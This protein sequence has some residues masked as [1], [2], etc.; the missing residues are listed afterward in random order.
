LLRDRDL[1]ASR[2]G[3]GTWVTWAGHES[4]SRAAGFRVTSTL[5]DDFKS[6]SG[7]DDLIDLTDA[8]VA[9]L[10]L[11]GNVA[12]SLSAETFSS[13]ITDYPY[14]HELL[15][16]PPL[17]EAV[18]AEYCK[19]G[20]STRPDQILIT[21]GS[22]QALKL[23]AESYL[24]E[25]SSVVVEGPTY[26]GALAVFRSALA[27][28]HSVRTD[29]AGVLP[30]HLEHV[31]R[32]VQPRL[33]YLVPTVHNPTGTCLPPAR[34]AAVAT[35][36]A[37]A[38]ITLID[39][40]STAD[41]LYSA[42]PPPLM[43]SYGDSDRVV[44]VGSMSKLFWGGLRVGW[45]RASLGIIRRLAIVKA[46]SDLGT[47]LTSQL[48]AARLFDAIEEAREERR[49]ALAANYEA[50][51]EM[52]RGHL[53]GW[54]WLTPAGGA[55]IWVRLPGANASAFASAAARRGVAISA[56]PAFSAGGEFEDFVRIP[57]GLAVR[58]LEAGI[59]RITRTWTNDYELFS[60][61]VPTLV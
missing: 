33:I 54:T 42:A 12:R 2:K 24:D 35:I 29:Q 1:L 48:L 21:S 7:E 13:L 58:D 16:Y 60:D 49:T 39:D 4:A 51:A 44:T 14:G 34:R 30:D 19:A 31:T 20:L 18:A 47:S 15:G 59:Q 38:K 3:S 11:V 40:C 27:A 6:R 53:P 56:G 32:V 8:S 57:Y 9:G 28:I 45:V 22:Q 25:G 52:L 46:R 55:S 23:L 5:D 36:V 17:R 37:S 41:T 43:A 61:R 26:R 50:L 10:G